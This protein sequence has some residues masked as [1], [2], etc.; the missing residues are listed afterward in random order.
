MALSYESLS[1]VVVVVVLRYM[2]NYHLVFRKGP[3]DPFDAAAALLAL[4]IVLVAVEERVQHHSRT[5]PAGRGHY[6]AEL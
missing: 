1:T 6:L 5:H 4:L 3:V 2:N